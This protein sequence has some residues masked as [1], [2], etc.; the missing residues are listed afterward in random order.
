MR[1][2]AAHSGFVVAAVA[3][4]ATAPAAWAHEVP[5]AE[6]TLSG[7]VVPL[8]FEIPTP[9]SYELPAVT[10]VEDYRLLNASAEPQALLGLATPPVFGPASTSCRR[11]RWPSIPTRAPWLSPRG[12]MATRQSSP[13]SDPLR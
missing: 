6:G 7:P 12:R 11:W 4:L 10:Q 5:E 9:G 8:A 3:L 2:G 1:G 13:E